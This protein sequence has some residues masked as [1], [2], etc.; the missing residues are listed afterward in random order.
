MNVDYKKYRNALKELAASPTGKE[1]LAYL[2]KAHVKS[3]ALHADVN[4]THY[5]LGQKEL[6]QNILEESKTDYVD[7]D[8]KGNDYE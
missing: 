3:S 1:L 5:L 8:I 7:Y 6:I 4:V 2:E